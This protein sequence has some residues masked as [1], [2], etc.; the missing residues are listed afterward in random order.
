MEVIPPGS[1]QLTVPGCSGSM[2]VVAWEDDVANL[3]DMDLLDGE[4]E[5]ITA[6]D[7]RKVV[8]D[9]LMQ[10]A[11][12]KRYVITRYGKPIAELHRPEPTAFELGAAVR[13]LGLAGS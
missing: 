3:R 8:G 5:T 2:P 13:R 11:L 10:V 7:F 6:V 9:V 4:V 1:G 12:G